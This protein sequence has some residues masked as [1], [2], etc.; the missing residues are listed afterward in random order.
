MAFSSAPFSSSEAGPVL[1]EVHGL[2]YKFYLQFD[3]PDFEGE[4]LW[5]IH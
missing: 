1:T 5:V 4:P 2:I 3:V